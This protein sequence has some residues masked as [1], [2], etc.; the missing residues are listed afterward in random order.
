MEWEESK[1]LLLNDLKGVKSETD[2]ARLFWGGEVYT[3]SEMIHEIE[4]ETKV[5]KEHIQLRIDAYKHIE[6]WKKEKS[7]KKKRWQFWK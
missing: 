2:K 7:S 3:I 4:N 5:G 1:R 6:E